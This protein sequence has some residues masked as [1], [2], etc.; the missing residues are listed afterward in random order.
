MVTFQKTKLKTFL[1][2]YIIEHE[3]VRIIVTLTRMRAVRGKKSLFLACHIP[4][5]SGSDH[6]MGEESFQPRTLTENTFF[7]F[8]P[9]PPAHSPFSPFLPSPSGGDAP[10]H[11]SSEAIKSF[12]VRRF[13]SALV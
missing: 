3:C 11:V 10:V 12:K 6:E 13:E 5:S 8:F 7:T 4:Y 2:I 1:H 9:P